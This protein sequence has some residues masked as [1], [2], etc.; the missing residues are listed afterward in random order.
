MTNGQI[1]RQK[2]VFQGRRR[3]T[4][5]RVSALHRDTRTGR[6]SAGRPTADKAADAAVTTTEQT[7][8]KTEAETKAEERAQKAQEAA[9]SEPQMAVQAAFQAEVDAW[10][11][12]HP[13]RP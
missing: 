9:H 7:A 12:A 5:G 2:S 4:G 3:K 10:F 8:A 1:D 6:N 11:A 13:A